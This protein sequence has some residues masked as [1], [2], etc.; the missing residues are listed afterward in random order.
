MYSYLSYLISSCD[1]DPSVY[2]PIHP[3]VYPSSRYGPVSGWVLRRRPERQ[4]CLSQMEGTEMHSAQIDSRKI[5]KVS[6]PLRR[7]IC[8]FIRMKTW[9]SSQERGLVPWLSLWHGGSNATV[10]LQVAAGAVHGNCWSEVNGCQ[11]YQCWLRLLYLHTTS[12]SWAL[13]PGPWLVSQAKN[14]QTCHSSETIQEK[15]STKTFDTLDLGAACWPVPHTI[16][17]ACLF[18]FSVWRCCQDQN[19]KSEVP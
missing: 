6:W 17:I 18:N 2:P 12:T 14:F 10:G 19:P 7:R 9:C 13:S 15:T 8:F 16:T 11:W 4:S 5:T 3:S 1:R